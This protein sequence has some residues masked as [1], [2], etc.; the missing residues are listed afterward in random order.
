[1][2]SKLDKLINGAYEEDE[3]K[4]V[5]SFHSEKSQ[6][7]KSHPKKFIFRQINQ[8]IQKELNPEK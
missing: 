7:V 6:D 4:S 3:I 1:M 2:K 8:I 5:S